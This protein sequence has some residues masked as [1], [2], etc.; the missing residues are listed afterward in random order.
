MIRRP[1][2]TDVLVVWKQHKTLFVPAILEVSE[3]VTKDGYMSY[4][5]DHRD[6]ST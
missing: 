5:A 6:A 3:V 2:V 4:V 1:F